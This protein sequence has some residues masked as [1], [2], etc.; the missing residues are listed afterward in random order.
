MRK[1][2]LFAASIMVIATAITVAQTPLDQ[3]SNLRGRTDELGNL[4][5]TAS[6]PGAQQ[7]PLTAL[8]NIRVRTDSNGYLMVA[9]PGSSNVLGTFNAVGGATS[10]FPAIK[11]N[12]AILEV[13]L[14]DDSAYGTLLSGNVSAVTFSGVAVTFASLGANANGDMAYC[15]DCTFA[16]PCAGA[17]TGAFAK[18]LNGAWRCD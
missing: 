4:L 11:R 14:G 9:M 5:V 13:K 8:A 2:L 10:A 18:R 16:N 12:G 1:Y 7:S 17:G 3:L 6:T 15:S